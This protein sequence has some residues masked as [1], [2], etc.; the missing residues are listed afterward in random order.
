MPREFV[1]VTPEP[2]TAIEI[3]AAT[4]TV[5][6]GLGMGRLWQGGGLQIAS[7]ESLV[8]AVLRSSTLEDP[9]DA[10]RLLGALPPDAAYLTE[11]YGPFDNDTTV[12]LVQELAAQTG[13]SLFAGGTS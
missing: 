6:P 11:A 9:S 4:N 2:I 1:I 8:L 10:Q 7:D 12:T 13:G 3:A 5:D